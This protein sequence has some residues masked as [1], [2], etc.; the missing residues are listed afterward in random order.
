[1][2]K[3]TNLQIRLYIIAVVMLLAG[4]T[5]AGI[6]YLS[7]EKDSVSFLGYDVE[8]GTVNP[9]YPEDSKLYKH[10]LELYGGKANVLASEFR[11]WF[12]GLWHGKSLAFTVAS[13]TVA[14]STGVFFIARR[15]P[16]DSGFPNRGDDSRG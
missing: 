5:G 3:N 7:V 12:V 16:S 1:M 14:I 9:I 13:I 8:W 10:N 6:I 4:L 15:L 11:Q 2:M